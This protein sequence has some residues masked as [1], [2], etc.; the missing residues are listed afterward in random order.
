MRPRAAVRLLHLYVG[1]ALC[2]LLFVLA[3]TGSALVY[4]EAWWRMV[5]PELRGPAAELRAADHARA[6]ATAQERF[7]ERLRSVKMPEPGV[8]GYHVYLDGG[9]AFLAADGIRVID[10]WRPRER[11]TGLLFD[12]H[13]HLLAGDAGE[14]VAG[15]VALLGVLAIVTGVALWWP[16]RRRFA[17]RTLLPHGLSRRMLLHWHRDLGVLVSPLLTVVLITG[18]GLVFYGTAGRVL[19]SL[20]GRP[21]GAEPPPPAFPQPA[22]TAGT[23]EILERIEVEF[24]DARLVFYYPPRGEQALHG[25]RLKRPCELHPNGRSY[26]YADA[27]G[28]VARTTDACAA[29]PGERVLHAFYPLHAGKADSPTYKL[30]TFLVGLALAAISLSGALAYVRRLRPGRGA[31]ASAWAPRPAD[32]RGAPAPRAHRETRRIR[33]SVRARDLRSAPVSAPERAPAAGVS[34]GAE[35]P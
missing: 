19:D 33:V 35:R 9:E 20:F 34:Q 31:R 25:F 28:R 3:V 7:G 22:R 21:L 4:K 8:D 11:V 1:L 30:L 5:Y 12:L 14:R 18:G 32:R 6:I 2:L 27:A 17:A 10:E 15:V 29:R 26:A 16:A 13:A 24:P 23:V